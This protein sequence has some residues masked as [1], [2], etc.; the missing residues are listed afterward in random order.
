MHCWSDVIKKHIYVYALLSLVLFFGSRDRSLTLT[1]FQWKIAKSWVKIA[2]RNCVDIFLLTYSKLRVATLNVLKFLTWN[3][4][5]WTSTY[6]LLFYHIYNWP[7]FIALLV[8]FAI[9]FHIHAQ[10][11]ILLYCIFVADIT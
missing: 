10:L 5:C 4:C 3:T 7:H 6:F 1:C 2:I 11:Y 9:I 8:L